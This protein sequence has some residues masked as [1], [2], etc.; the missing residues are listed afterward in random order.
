MRAIMSR[1][2]IRVRYPRSMM[3]IQKALGQ[4]TSGITELSMLDII[5]YRLIDHLIG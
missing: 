1:L 4:Q 2:W 5:W 3:G